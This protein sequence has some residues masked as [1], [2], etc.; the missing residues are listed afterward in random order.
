MT[1]SS[2]FKPVLAGVYATIIDKYYMQE[3]DM[4]R[5]LYF[6]GAVAVGIYTSEYLSPMVNLI[7]HIPSLNVQLYNSKTLAQRITE[8]G[9]GASVT[10]VLNRYILQN[11][12]Y[13]SEI[14]IRVAIIGVSDVLAE[15]TSDYFNGR[16][17]SY[18]TA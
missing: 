2:M 6:G 7:G 18:L 13:K 17:L 5:S 9:T 14:L 12:I 16:S 3:P 8:V 10:F 15:Y 1:D 11:D 4:T